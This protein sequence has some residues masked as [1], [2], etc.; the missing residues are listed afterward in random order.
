M[1]AAL[2][3]SMPTPLSGFLGNRS[4]SRA[5]LRP[6]TVTVNGT[7]KYRNGRKIRCRNS[8]HPKGELHPNTIVSR[9][10]NGMPITKRPD[11]NV[12]NYLLGHQLGSRIRDRTQRF[13]QQGRQLLRR[14]PARAALRLAPAREYDANEPSNISIASTGWVEGENVAHSVPQ[15]HW[16]SVG[17]PLAEA[18][19]LRSRSSYRYNGLGENYLYRGWLPVARAALRPMT[20][21]E[22]IKEERFRQRAAEQAQ[23]RARELYR[24]PRNIS[25]SARKVKSLSLRKSKRTS[26]RSS[27][28]RSF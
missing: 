28:K 12:P 6:R 8:A 17:H 9:L 22:M 16:G 27:K 20:A 7:R 5:A 14:N 3:A 13:L 18:T 10:P 25:R 11:S 1:S 21:E 23:R 4:V 15:G 24:S 26:K 19:P 2:R